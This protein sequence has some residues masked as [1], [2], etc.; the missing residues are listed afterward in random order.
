MIAFAQG[1]FTPCVQAFGAEQFDEEDEIEN[2]AK[3][4]FFNW[5]YCFVVGGVLVP[6]LILTYIQE[7]VSWEL[8]FGIPAI[9][10]CCSLLLFL[11]GSPTYRFRIYSNGRN[12]FIRIHRVIVRAAKN[13]QAA[14]IAVSTEE[15][16]QQTLPHKGAGLK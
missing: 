6:L 4:S 15:E 7:N 8:G 2:K 12:P 16:G 5:W 9:V 11:I 14:P 1:G 10:M 13:R 3:S